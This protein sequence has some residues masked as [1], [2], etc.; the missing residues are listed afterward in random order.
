MYMDILI[1]SQLMQSPKHG[2]EIKKN[3]GFILGKSNTI[4]NNYLY[5]TLKKF[6]EMGA[7]DKELEVQDN[8]PNRHIYAITDLGREVFYELLNEFPEEYATNQNEIY[9]RLAFFEL[10]NNSMKHQLIKYRKTFLEE[11]LAHLESLSKWEGDK[12]FLPFSSHLYTY[13]QQ[14]LMK[15][16]EIFEQMEKEIED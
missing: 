7:V 9:N 3:V 8:K 12:L 14:L 6:E 5:P 10:L 4:N 11:N 16:L 2:Y 15:E 1:L 13:S